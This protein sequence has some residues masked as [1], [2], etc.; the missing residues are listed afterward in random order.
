M[1][2]VS[3]KNHHIAAFETNIPARVEDGLPCP[4]GDYGPEEG[5]L[6]HDQRQIDPVPVLQ[7][8]LRFLRCRQRR[9]RE[10]HPAFYALSARSA[11]NAASRRRYASPPTTYVSLWPAPGMGYHALGSGAAPNRAWPSA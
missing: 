6:A 1:T 5:A 9:E 11:A 7:C 10:A 8:V 3:Q 4:G 2:F